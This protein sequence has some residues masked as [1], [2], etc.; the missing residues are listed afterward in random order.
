MVHGLSKTQHTDE[1]PKRKSRQRRNAAET[2]FLNT[3]QLSLAY[4]R[5]I[6][7]G[8]LAGAWAEFGG[9]GALLT[10]LAST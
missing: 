1:L 3:G 10:N 7:V 8:E 2:A 6:I 9:M 5:Y 4:L